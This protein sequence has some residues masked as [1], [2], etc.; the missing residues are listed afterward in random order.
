MSLLSQFVMKHN[1]DGYSLICV[2]EAIARQVRVSTDSL[3][4]VAL[5]DKNAADYLISCVA[6]IQQN[7]QERA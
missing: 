7:G 5:V 3:L 6:R 1:V 2:V 4:A